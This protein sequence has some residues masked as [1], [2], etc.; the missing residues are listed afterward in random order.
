MEELIMKLKQLL[1]VGL[2]VC[3]VGSRAWAMEDVKGAP[4]VG[5]EQNKLHKLKYNKMIRYSYTGLALGFGGAT[6]YMAYQSFRT[7]SIKNITLTGIG[8]IGTIMFGALAWRVRNEYTRLAPLSLNKSIKERNEVNAVVKDIINVVEEKNLQ[9][10]EKLKNKRVGYRARIDRLCEAKFMVGKLRD[11]LKELESISCYDKNITQQQQELDK[12]IKKQEQVQE[13]LVEYSKRIKDFDLVPLNM[14]PKQG[15]QLPELD[16]KSPILHSLEYDDNKINPIL[17]ELDKVIKNQEQVRDDI[18]NG[19]DKQKNLEIELNKNEEKQFEE[20]RQRQPVNDQRKKLW[21]QANK[22]LSKCCIRLAPHETLLLVSPKVL[23]ES[24]T[25]DAKTKQHGARVWDISEL[26]KKSDINRKVSNIQLRKVVTLFSN[27]ADGQ[28]ATCDFYTLFYT[29]KLAEL[30][31]NNPVLKKCKD[32]LLTTPPEAKKRPTY[33]PD[34]QYFERYGDVKIELRN[35]EKKCLTTFSISDS[36][37]VTIRDF[38]ELPDKKRLLV[39]LDDQKSRRRYET[40][41]TTNFGRHGYFILYD[42]EN[43]KVIERYTN[44]NDIVFPDRI[45]SFK[46]ENNQN[47]HII[48]PTQ[49]TYS[50]GLCNIKIIDSLTG[51]ITAQFSD[52]TLPYF[53][54]AEEGSGTGRFLP[55]DNK[56]FLIWTWNE[57]D[58]SGSGEP[59]KRFPIVYL[60][61]LETQKISSFRNDEDH[62]EIVNVQLL[63][64]DRLLLCSLKKDGRAQ[65]K[66]FDLNTEKEIDTFDFSGDET[67]VH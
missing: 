28:D 62:K 10:K 5:T 54:L 20:G 39:L 42:L 63:P 55:I 3:T 49:K 60:F 35:S 9:E 1:W 45:F 11:K 27:I 32:A 38:W 7:A 24:V 19:V 59:T 33:L 21:C 44:I 58:Y 50:N 22:A 16:K 14:R 56:R 61:N 36:K 64:F 65:I 25:H 48:I 15:F 53:F 43:K 67:T 47:S 57:I 2:L 29:A 4:V 46:Q 66:I 37:D 12:A 17:S 34:G 40:K 18:K 31:Q 6:A 51:K 23:D 26:L 41:N 8:I 52:A 13:R 30:L